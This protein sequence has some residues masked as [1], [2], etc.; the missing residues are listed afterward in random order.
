MKRVSVLFLAGVLLAV[1]PAAAPAQQYDRYERYDRRPPA[2][3][4]PAPPPRHAVHGQ[5]YFFGHLGIFEPNDR[6]DGLRGYDSDMA[7]DFGI[8]SRVS[9]NLA[10]EGGLGVYTADMGRNEVAVVPLT[11]GARLILPGP[12]VEPYFG[13]GFGLYFADLDE[14]A[15][16]IDDSDTTLGGY[17]S[18]GIDAWLNPRTALNFEGKYH[19]AEPRFDGFDVDVSGWT[20][21]LGVRVSF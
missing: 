19:I 16:G 5:T 6:A 20:L 10:V 11:I 2:R 21:S 17:L 18:L 8:G 7:F 9:P 15:S 1:F 3:P 4:A 12:V 13:G 14:P